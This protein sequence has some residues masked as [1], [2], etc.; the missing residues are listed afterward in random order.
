M[1]NKPI[2]PLHRLEA[3]SSRLYVI[4]AVAT[5]AI[6]IA[7]CIYTNISPAWSGL[8]LIGIY[9]VAALGVFLIINRQLKRYRQDMN[10]AE[11]QSNSVIHAFRHQLRLPYAVVSETGRIV[12]INA[13]MRS[14]TN[15]WVKSMVLMFSIF[16]T[17][18]TPTAG[19]GLILI[20]SVSL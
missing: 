11:E 20:P 12:T 4:F 9:L 6:H 10:A 2:D 19:V 3:L 18:I 17:P 14:I 5:V 13:A 8:I 1:A 15:T 7:L 16:S